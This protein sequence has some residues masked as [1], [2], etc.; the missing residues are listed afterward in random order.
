MDIQRDPS[1]LDNLPSF[2]G[3]IKL[4]VY[5]I[6]ALILLQVELKDDFLQGATAQ[7]QIKTRIS[8]PVRNQIQYDFRISKKGSR[9]FH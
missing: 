3:R 5:A 8:L 9:I 1:N 2:K 6:H 7:D 4:K